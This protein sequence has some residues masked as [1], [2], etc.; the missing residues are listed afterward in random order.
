MALPLKAKNK[1]LVDE[2]YL[3][4][5]LDRG[6]KKLEANYSLL[7]KFEKEFLKKFK[8]KEEKK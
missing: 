2:P 5:I 1:L 7:D 3:H 6:N 8:K 4:F